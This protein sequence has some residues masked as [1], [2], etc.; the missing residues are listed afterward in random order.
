[1]KLR[2]LPLAHALLACAVLPLAVHAAE[3]K[4]LERVPLGEG[5][6]TFRGTM[7]NSAVLVAA[8]GVLLIDAGESPE[9]AARLQAAIAAITARPVTLLVNTHW[10]FD[11]VNGNGVF[12]RQGAVIVGQQAMRARA[13]VSERGQGA[14]PLPPAEQP[15]VTFDRELTLNLGGEAVRLLHPQTGKAH[16]D[17]DTVVVFPKANVVHMGDLYFE[18]MYPYIDVEAGG[19]AA[20]MAAAI[21]ELLPLMNEQTKVVPGHGPLSD[22]QK[23]AAFADMLID[24]SSRVQAQIATGQT[25]DA[26]RA[27]KPTATYDAQWGHGFMK[28]DG[29]VELVYRGLTAR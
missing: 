16:T 13:A 21:R 19:S 28:P 25:L 23:L 29:F 27:A 3:D 17:G 22:R 8:E 12:A 4:P 20:G 6:S 9:A 10:H 1:M 2:F 7:A 11:H 5:L 18:G 15:V 26:I 24:V 14:G